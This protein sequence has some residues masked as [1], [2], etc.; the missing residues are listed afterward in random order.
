M[1]HKNKS[2]TENPP[3]WDPPA[4]ATVYIKIKDIPY[5]TFKTR[6]NQGLVTTELDQIRYRL[7]RRVY[8]CGT[9]S[10]Y[11]DEYC[12]VTSSSPEPGGICKAF[13]PKP[14]FVYTD[15]RPAFGKDGEDTGFKY[16]AEGGVQRDT[17]KVGEAG[18]EECKSPEALYEDGLALYKQGRL[19][20]AL[21]AFDRVLAEKPGHFA[22]LF[23]N[24]VALLKLKR[25]EEAL[26]AFETALKLNPGHAATWANKGAVL[27]K[28][29]RFQEALEAFEKSLNL[30][31]LQKNAWNGKD[32]MLVQ[33]RRSRKT[34]ETYEQALKTNPENAAALFEKGKLN[35]KLGEQEKAREAFEKALKRTPDNAEAWYLRGKV[36]FK[37][38][39][40]KE[41]L[42]AFEKATRLKPGYAAAWYEKGCVFLDLGNGRGAENAFKISADLWESTREPEKAGK[43]RDKIRKI[44]QDS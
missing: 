34:L 32:A 13:V 3:K 9:C 10:K 4:P 18:A 24:G 26:T 20:M 7:E 28:L 15:V 39:T 17:G 2:G 16:L 35:L 42:H 8:C 27:V 41:A 38:G 40:G 30:N 19:K 37:M 33:V 12:V 29:E 36:L 25:Y 44:R 11:V 1:K 43:A 5:E 31:P 6:L 22:T 14:E 23:Y 21:A